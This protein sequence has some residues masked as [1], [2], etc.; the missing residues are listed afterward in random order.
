MIWP[1]IILLMEAACS[2]C[3][4]SWG[5][6]AFM[7]TNNLSTPLTQ[8]LHDANGDLLGELRIF[9]RICDMVGALDAQDPL[10]RC[11]KSSDIVVTKDGNPNL[12][13]PS[14]EEWASRQPHGE[15]YSL[16]ELLYQMI[17]GRSAPPLVLPKGELH[18]IVC[19]AM[20]WQPA[21]EY[22]SSVELAGDVHAFLEN[23]LGVA[24]QT[25][26]LAAATLAA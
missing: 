19:G 20:Q 17:T 18:R 16:G 1:G 22:R 4:R 23:E 14:E 6:K 2:P 8:F 7:K 3:A 21:A 24:S 9:L 26:P 5:R 12:V 10:R 11:L 15:V 13:K 25:A